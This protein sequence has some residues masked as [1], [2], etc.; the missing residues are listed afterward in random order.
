ML[1]FLAGRGV[2]STVRDRLIRSTEV[3]E[4]FGNAHTRQN[5]NSSRFG[6]FIEVHLVKEEVVGAS[7]T[8]YMLEAQRKWP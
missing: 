8:P 3:L 1:S 2:G 7:L 5:C 6:K 4:A